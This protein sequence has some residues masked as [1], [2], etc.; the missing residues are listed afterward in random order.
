VNA[1]ADTTTADRTFEA[2]TWQ[3]TLDKSKTLFERSGK[4]RKQASILL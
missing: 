3:A 2:G 4:A 1:T